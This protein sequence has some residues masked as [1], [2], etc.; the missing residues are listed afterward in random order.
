MRIKFFAGL[1]IIIA[2]PRNTTFNHSQNAMSTFFLIE[3]KLEPKYVHLTDYTLGR[4]QE[5]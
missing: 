4:I 1:K 3:K 2:I 5:H